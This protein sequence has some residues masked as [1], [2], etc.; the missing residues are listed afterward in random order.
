MSWV[1]R[2]LTVDIY[3]EEGLYSFTKPAK[4]WKWKILSVNFYNGKCS[5]Y[6]FCVE[7]NWVPEWL[8]WSTKGGPCSMYLAGWP[9]ASH[10][11]WTS[12]A[13]QGCCEGKKSSRETGNINLPCSWLEGWDEWLD[14]NYPY[15]PLTWNTRWT[16]KE[17]KPSTI[18]FASSP[19]PKK[20]FF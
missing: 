14:R 1:I 2:I 7:G 8:E 5:S 15:L 20:D 4:S 9:W 13:S 17:T 12:L 18:F 3:L 16:L 11:L 10:C 19:I 6:I